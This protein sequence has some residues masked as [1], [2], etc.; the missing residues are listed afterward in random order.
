M[1]EILFNKT[2]LIENS[3]LVK[4]IFVTYIGSSGLMR[5]SCG[6]ASSITGWSWSKM[7]LLGLGYLE[8]LVRSSV[9]EWFG[10]NIA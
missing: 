6:G 3:A 8:K 9:V 1:M 7:W 2:T 10:S 4:G 5:L